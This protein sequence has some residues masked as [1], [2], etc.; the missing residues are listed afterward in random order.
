MASPSQ[1]PQQGPDCET[2]LFTFPSQLARRAATLVMPFQRF[3]ELGLYTLGLPFGKAT[4]DIEW[5]AL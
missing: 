5:E 1:L 4:R 3:T 2:V